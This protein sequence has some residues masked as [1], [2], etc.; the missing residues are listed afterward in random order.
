V[1]DTIQVAPVLEQIG[2]GYERFFK[3]KKHQKIRQALWKALCN[4][5]ILYGDQILLWLGNLPS[6][7]PMTTLI[8]C[9]YNLVLLHFGFWKLTGKYVTP[10][11]E[12]NFNARIIVYGDD[13]NI[14]VSPEWKH[15]VDGVK[16]AELFA[17]YG[18]RYT[19]AT[20]GELVP[21]VT[22]AETT[23]LKR[24]FLY[25]S[26]FR[27]W[28]CPLELTT[29]LE[30]ISWTKTGPFMESIPIEK[31]STALTE[32]AL[33]EKTTFDEWAPRIIEASKE[34]LHFSPTITDQRR[35]K[36]IVL[37]YE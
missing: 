11:L 34:Y 23:F 27:H 10:F 15:L 32:L 7:H 28:F 29:I 13:N 19:N 37:N 14:H 8:N 6:G 5:L 17:K 18:M 16:L 24:R 1:F 12:T 3:D 36:M 20:K 9:T 21:F 33:H 26:E 2:I 30:M 31:V 35:L 22:L 25:D 4:A